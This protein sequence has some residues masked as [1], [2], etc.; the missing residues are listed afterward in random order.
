M[1]ARANVGQAHVCAETA[2][3]STPRNFE[4]AV[5]RAA[6][7][8][9]ADG[10]DPSHQIMLTHKML[11]R[12]GGAQIEGRD[13]FLSRPAAYLI[14]MNGDPSK[15]EIA[16]AQ[17]YFAVKT[18]QMELEDQKSDDQKRLEAREKGELYT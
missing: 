7:A 12:G 15:P 8:F 9:R 14:A 6:D 10:H 13:Y 4:A 3:F 5:K 2:A 18:R 1:R 17:I 11:E 16:A